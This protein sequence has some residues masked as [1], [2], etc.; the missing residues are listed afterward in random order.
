MNNLST[1]LPKKRFVSLFLPHFA[2]E[3]HERQPEGHKRQNAPFALVDLIS[4]GQR[5]WAVDEAARKQGLVRNMALSDALALCPSLATKQAAPQKDVRRLLQL[6]SWC[7]RYSPLSNVHD[8]NSLWIDVTGS[9]HLFAGE[10][11][12][13]AAI[14]KDFRQQGYTVKLALAGSFAAAF[15]LSHFVFDDKAKAPIIPSQSSF[16]QLQHYLYSLPVT[17]L[18]LHENTCSLLHRLGLMTLGQLMDLPRES[19]KRRFPS[20][21]QARSV[22]FRLD[23][24]LELRDEPL[25]PLTPP[26][27]F[28]SRLRFAQALF[29][30]HG[31]ERAL[32]RLLDDVTW[33]LE[34]QNQGARSLTFSLWRSDGSTSHIAIGTAQPCR[35]KA[36]LFNLFKE[37]ISR[38]EPGFGIDVIALF[39]AKAEPLSVKQI[40]LQSR[41]KSDRSRSPFVLIDRL[42]NHLGAQKIGYL[43]ALPSHIPERAQSLTTSSPPQTMPPLH[44]A[45]PASPSV[46][47]D[48]PF[49][50]L[51]PPESIDVLAPLPDDPPLSFTWRRVTRKVITSNGP[52]RLTREWWRELGQKPSRPRDYYKV[53]TREGGTFWL[54]RNGLYQGSEECRSPPQWFIHGFFG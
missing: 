49:L 23:Q 33:Q 6:A 39:V 28:S 45:S 8:D 3:N 4:K 16:T 27:L 13:L 41:Q 15:A 51:N 7:E 40:S 1:N 9:T 14:S 11:G 2:I 25:A 43:Q 53:S 32:T 42:R 22:L 5:L 12:L 10:Q 34:R 20:P 47:Y 37:K 30:K 52:E 48:R 50:L 46:I 54:Y 29:S 38:I 17:A 44:A 35:D 26:V 31:L 24:I 19:L 18:R 36:H 21:D